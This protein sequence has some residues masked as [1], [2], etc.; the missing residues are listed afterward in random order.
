[1]S[2]YGIEISRVELQ[3]ISLP[4]ELLAAAVDAYKASY[5]PR[6]AEWM[7]QARKLELEAEAHRLKAESDILGKEAIALREV[8]ANTNPSF[9]GL[10]SFLEQFFGQMGKTL[11]KA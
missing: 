11:G 8:L 2:E 10:P 1:M 5:L 9:I 7:A 3:E 4:P 6:K